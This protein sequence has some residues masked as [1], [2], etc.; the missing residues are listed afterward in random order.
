MSIP[1][2]IMGVLLTYMDNHAEMDMIK[3]MKK[4][5]KL[6]EKKFI[7]LIAKAHF[8]TIN[9]FKTENLSKEKL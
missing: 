8:T 4:R 5:K 9:H 1:Q 7:K 6:I 2:E 3:K